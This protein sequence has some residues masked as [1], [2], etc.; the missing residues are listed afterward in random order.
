M[1]IFI[2]LNLLHY[3]FDGTARRHLGALTVNRSCRRST[4]L[5][6]AQNGIRN[7]PHS[8]T[9]WCGASALPFRHSV[10]HGHYVQ[11]F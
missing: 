11:I 3:N 6:G 7:R 2:L 1:Y 9:L 5:K 4:L 8:P 10:R